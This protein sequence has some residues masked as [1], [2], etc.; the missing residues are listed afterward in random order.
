[1][2]QTTFRVASFNVENLFARPKV[3]NF[4]DKS[5]GAA[6]L[7]RIGDFNKILKK[8]TYSDDDKVKLVQEFNVGDPGNGEAPLKGFILIREDKGKLWKKSNRVITGVSAGGRGDWDGGIEFL[9]AKFSEVGRENTGKVVRSVKADVACI[10][11]ADNRSTLQGFDTHVLHSKY[12]YEMLID[13]NDRRGI[14]VGLYS[15]FPLG[16]IR[17]HIFDGTSRSRTFSRDCPE[18]EVFLPNGESL[19]VLCNHLKSK[20]YDYGGTADARRKKQAQAIAD[21]LKRYN[22]KKDWV[23][24]AGDMNDTPKSAA[25]KPLMDV[26]DLHDVL[27]LQYPNDPKKRWTYHYKSFEQIDYILVSKPLK[28]KFI[29]AGV[30]RKGMYD[31]KNLTASDNTIDDETQY[32]GVTHWTNAASDHGAVWA[33][34]N[35]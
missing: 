7:K 13:G 18:Y 4:R 12:R 21:I 31:L 3:F 16:N 8:S 23:V 15:R 20:G 10:V 14:D 30:Q 11:E 6:L 17:T 25:L 9:K 32:S 2:P 5:V 27:E 29:K 26:A 19:H 35:V 1:M 34:F 33:D 24:V 22:L 28:D